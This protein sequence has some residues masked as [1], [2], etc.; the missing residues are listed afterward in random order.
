[1]RTHSQ[2]IHD[3]GGPMAI[4]RRLSLSATI[5]TIRSWA[6]RNS[7]PAEY[8]SSVATAKLATLKELADAAEARRLS[9]A[10]DE[11]D[12][13]DDADPRQRAA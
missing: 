13:A 3:A 4:K 2:I 6:A 7:I 9:P 10:N 11:S 12:P 5:H 1:M 8:W